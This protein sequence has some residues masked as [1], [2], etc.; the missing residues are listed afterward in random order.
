MSEFLAGV[1]PSVRRSL[2]PDEALFRQGEAARYVYRVITGRVQLCRHLRAGT[3]VVIAGASAGETFAEPAIFNDEY[4][5][6]AIAHGAAEVEGFRCS[7]IHDR[8]SSDAGAAK[9]LCADLA[10]LVMKLRA[11]IEIRTIRA[12]PERLLAW[13][14]LNARGTPPVFTAQPT[15]QTVAFEIGVTQE[16]LYR[17]LSTLTRQRR[18]K[19]LSQRVCEFGALEPDQSSA[20]PR[21]ESGAGKR[22]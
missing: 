20:R 13:M 21:A 8:I 22:G 15:W 18:I 6:D 3:K 11:R 19:R 14:R 7:E 4:H 2:A 9:A 17:A 12:A 5:C 16:S 1:S 10:R